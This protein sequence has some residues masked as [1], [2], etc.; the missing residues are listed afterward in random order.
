MK[1]PGEVIFQ[2]MGQGRWL[3]YN[4]FTRQCLGVDS[5]AV[6]AL[7]EGDFAQEQ[8]SEPGKRPDSFLIW[9]VNWFSNYD[10]LL[11]DP[12][13][14]RR[15]AQAWRDPQ[16]VSLGGL[17]EKLVS[18]CLLVKDEQEYR[19]RFAPKNSLLDFKNFGNFHQQLGQELLLKRK[20]D[21]YAWWVRQKFTEDSSE[22]RQ[23]N[24][25]GAVQYA[26]LNDYFSRLIK[27]GEAIVD[28][29]C[30]TGFY[31]ALM[32]SKGAQVLAV[33][34]NEQFIGM[35]QQKAPAGMTARVMEVGQKGGL[36]AL[37]DDSA[38]IVF[39]SDAMLFYFVPE[40]PDQKGDLDVLLSDV[41]RIMKPGGLFVSVEPHYLFWL[42]PWMGQTEHPFT[43]FT[44][45]MN[46]SFGVTAR[47]S[48]L[49]Q[50]LGKNRLM[51]SWMDEM[52]PAPSFK[53]VDARAY[54]FAREFPLWQIIEC[55]K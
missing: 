6:A 52:L 46:K 27:G 49:V 45:Y 43:V 7:S 40:S 37:P 36:D 48:Q 4:L 23:D 41:R 8:A 42:A 15:D 54:A 44:E 25:Y 21:P 51:V 13:R 12:T 35:A 28:L 16:E 5:G 14:I 26:Y 2:P 31:S 1:I 17:I 19:S 30:G 53:D 29:G 34:P 39:M 24:L 18:L 32:A 10:G 11:A 33:D 50:A 55:R 22:V 3:I 9:E 38:D 47:F 20:E